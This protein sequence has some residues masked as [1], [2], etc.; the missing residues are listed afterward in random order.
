MQ[1]L[2]SFP[3]IWEKKIQ[4][5]INK[6]I[7][8]KFVMLKNRRTV[9]KR[10]LVHNK[11]PRKHYLLS[12]LKMRHAGE[13]ERLVVDLLQPRH[14]QHWA[15]EWTHSGPQASRVKWAQAGGTG[16]GDQ[17]SG[18]GPS[19]TRHSHVGN[20]SQPTLCLIGVTAN[21]VFVSIGWELATDQW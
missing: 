14:S 6:I 15:L 9:K 5:Q 11:K 4:F 7:S 21:H 19:P 2:D 10:T 12:Q 16:P 13:R 20:P 3:S 1:I 17:W 18:P 8:S